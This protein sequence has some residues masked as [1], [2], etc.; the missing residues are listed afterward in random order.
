MKTYRITIYPAASESYI[1]E[2][3]DEDE[4]WKNYIAGDG[5]FEELEDDWDDWKDPEIEEVEDEEEEE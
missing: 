2:A 5:D 4:A 1:V 3:E